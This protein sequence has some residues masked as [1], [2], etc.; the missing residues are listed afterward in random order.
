M[1]FGSPKSPLVIVT[2]PDADDHLWAEA[3]NL[4]ASDVLA[5]PFDRGEVTRALFIAVLNWQSKYELRPVA[6]AAGA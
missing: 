2:S 4:G 1:V 3:L 5:K 6:K